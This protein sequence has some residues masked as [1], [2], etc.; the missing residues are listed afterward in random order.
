[1]KKLYLVL[2]FLCGCFLTAFGVIN[3]VN[4]KNNEDIFRVINDACVY[5]AGSHAAFTSLE[6][7][8][9][10]LYLA[11]REA[12]NHISSAGDR[13][14]IKI[15]VK[16]DNKW[17][18]DYIFSKEG[19]DLRDPYLLKWEGKLFLY[20][21]GHVSELT[22]KGWT[23]LKPIRHNAPHPLNIWKIRSYKK[24]LY[25]VGN[26]FDKWP[27]LMKS[28]DGINWAVVAEYK[29]GG[30]ASEADL[31]FIG[32][33]LFIC[34][35]IDNPAGTNSMWGVSKYPFNVAEWKMLDASIASPEMMVLSS[36]K[37]LIAGREY[38]FNKKY[39]KDSINVSLFS[40][41]RDG[42]VA[43]EYVFDTGRLGDK[44]YPSFAKYNNT[45][46]MSYYTGKMDETEVHFVEFK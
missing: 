37:I 4:N 32:D 41:N 36:N 45:L 26:R 6:E 20:A 39:G 13:G 7:Y 24:E 44:G 31:S 8:N 14:K 42:I 40:M 46:C 25:G 10:K 16:K 11:F 43:R 22:K 2:L 28:K 17:E 5:E 3:L 35:R 1:M 27:M 30:Y 23:D 29:L 15:L 33:S 21:S 19:L 34:I 18:K 12:K 38:D 9:G